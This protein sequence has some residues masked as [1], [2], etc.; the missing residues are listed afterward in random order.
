MIRPRVDVN[1]LVDLTAVEQRGLLEAGDVSA[2][3]LLDA[4]LDRVEQVNPTVNAVVALDPE[5]GRARA[6][7]VDEAR[8]AGRPMGP[9]AGLVTAHKDLTDTADFPTTLG[10]PLFADRRPKT[11]SL[12]VSRVKAAGA[13]AI[14]KT[15]TPEFGR[16]SHTFNPVYGITRNPYDTTRTAGGSSGGAAVSLATSMVAIAD[17]S[18]MG[19]SL[20]NPAGWNNVV[21]FRASPGVVPSV[22]PGPPW[23]RLG[24]EGA[25]GRTVD[26]LVLLLEVLSP[27]H[28]ADP[29]SAGLDSSE[30]KAG[31]GLV[32]P[33]DR[34]LRVAWSPQLGGLPV[35]ADV[36]DALAGVPDICADLGWG[37][38][39]A[40]PDFSDADEVFATLRGWLMAHGTVAALGDRRSQLKE[41]IQL[42]A[43]GG[44]E[45]TAGQVY[46]ALARLGE[47]WRRAAS[48]FEHYDL[49]LGPVSQV[50]P[51]PVETEYPMVIDGRPMDSYIDWM[52]S[53]C[54]I[55]VMG[56]PAAS[57]P[58][59][60]T[61]GGL[62]TGVQIIGGPGADITVLRAAKSFEQATGGH[63]ARRPPLLSLARNRSGS[64]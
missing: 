52:R 54:R 57:V 8:A 24:T 47:L 11:D 2:R 21:G 62:P 26:D 55:T 29:L 9:L 16:G 12:L 23:P 41:T 64:L 53:C 35:E 63:Y 44:A 38:E 46:G 56:S 20:R 43:A 28:L 15:N 27:R 50:S 3:E 14:G 45:V 22:A 40:Q 25:M 13:V 32:A 10:S 1:T 39:E 51:F 60:F 6:A 17:G 31:D 58:A 5:I 61:T 18:D 59:G 33:M 42:E 7:A 34:P 36:R 49:L 37:I 4:H 48:F 19:G 30:L